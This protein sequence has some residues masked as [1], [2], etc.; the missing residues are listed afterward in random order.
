MEYHEGADTDQDLQVSRSLAEED[1][2]W[3]VSDNL[4]EKEGDEQNSCRKS[5]EN[6]SPFECGAL[7]TDCSPL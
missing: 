2:A 1:I 7:Q 6:F 3:S 4:T 5:T